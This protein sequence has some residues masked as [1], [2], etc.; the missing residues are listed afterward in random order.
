MPKRRMEALGGLYE[1]LAN[2][3]KKSKQKVHRDVS[4][5]VQFLT[6]QHY[7][8]YILISYPYRYVLVYSYLFYISK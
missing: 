7:K 2:Q 3:S 5:H 8:S 1:S 6:K 4:K